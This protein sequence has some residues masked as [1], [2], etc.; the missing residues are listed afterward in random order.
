[1]LIS[2]AFPDFQPRLEVLQAQTWVRRSRLP[3]PVSQVGLLGESFVGRDYSLFIVAIAAEIAGMWAITRYMPLQIAYGLIAATVVLDLLFAIWHHRT[4]C[5]RVH[6]VR[7]LVADIEVN[8]AG[9]NHNAVAAGYLQKVG[10]LRAVSFIPAIG[11]VAITCGKIFFFYK[12]NGMRLDTTLVAM[13]CLYIVVCLVHLFVTGYV[14]AHLWASGWFGL[15]GYSK[16]LAQYKSNSNDPRFSPKTYRQK[17]HGTAALGEAL[18]T[19]GKKTKLV[20][21]DQLLSCRT[22]RLLLG[23]A[24]ASLYLEATGVLYDDDITELMNLFKRSVDAQTEVAKAALF[25]QSHKII[26]E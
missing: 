2:R 4:T 13:T 23:E 11:L 19:A 5:P 7:A 12:V 14:L 22:H 25:I 10:R 16:D 17:L 20:E 21:G 9:G 26:T 8:N 24:A 1:M 6:S 3:N 15:W 18:A